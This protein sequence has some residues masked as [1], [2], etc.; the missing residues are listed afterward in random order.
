MGTAQ[1]QDAGAAAEDT[2]RWEEEEEEELELVWFAVV[3]DTIS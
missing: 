1:Y 3:V 2:T